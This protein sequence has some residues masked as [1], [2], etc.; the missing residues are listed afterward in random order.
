MGSMADWPSGTTPETDAHWASQ[1]AVLHGFAQVQTPDL[2]LR[3]ERA[4]EG[5]HFLANEIGCASP[6]FTP[7][8]TPAPLHDTPQLR[9]AARDAYARDYLA[10]GW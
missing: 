9:A 10:F 4:A 2:V 8:A 6:A 7:D 1:S 5:L 3:P